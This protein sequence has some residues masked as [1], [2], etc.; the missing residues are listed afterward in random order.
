MSHIR[1]D[2]AQSIPAFFPS[3]RHAHECARR[4]VLKKPIKRKRG[5]KGKKGEKR[6]RGRDLKIDFI[7][8]M[9]PA[10]NLKS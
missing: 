5:K 10:T 7:S 4:N 2:I 6:K 8:H 3:P 9:L 1:S